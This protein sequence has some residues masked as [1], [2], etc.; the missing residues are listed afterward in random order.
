[1][2]INNLKT[3]YLKLTPQVLKVRAAFLSRHLFFLRDGSSIQVAAAAPP[4]PPT[5]PCHHHKRKPPPLWGTAPLTDFSQSD[6]P[7]GLSRHG[8]QPRAPGLPEPGLQCPQPSHCAG[9]HPDWL[10]GQ[11]EQEDGFS[12]VCHW[13]CSWPGK[14]LEVSVHM[15]SEWWRWV[16]WRRMLWRVRGCATWSSVCGTTGQKW[17]NILSNLNYAENGQ[18]TRNYPWCWNA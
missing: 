11:V 13:L 9:P 1:M 8:R 4:T 2:T 16:C 7:T 3:T 17:L 5:R 15:L 12:L 6:A 18:K 10:Q 14:C